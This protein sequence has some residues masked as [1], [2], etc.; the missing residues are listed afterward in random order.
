MIDNT[1]RLKGGRPWGT[2]AASAE[3]WPHSRTTTS[4]PGA[5]SAWGVQ[6]LGCLEYAEATRGNPVGVRE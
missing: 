6:R 1:I 2:R 4:V 5:L 3:A